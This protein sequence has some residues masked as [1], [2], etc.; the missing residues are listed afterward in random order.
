MKLSFVIIFIF[1][2]VFTSCNNDDIPSTVSD[3]STNNW[4]TNSNQPQLPFFSETEK[5]ITVVSEGPRGGSFIPTIGGL[6]AYRLFRI[7]IVNSNTVA[8]ELEMSLEKTVGLIRPALTDSLR[9]WLIPDAYVPSAKVDQFNF[10]IE[11]LEKLL[12]TCQ[13]KSPQI[14]CQ[15]L[16]Q[17]TKYVYLVALYKQDRDLARALVYFTHQPPVVSFLPTDT[18]AA[19]NNNE[20]SLGL[21]FGIGIDPPTNYAYF[22]CG[23]ITF[24]SF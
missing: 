9:I 21:T 17:L 14:K 18:S 1:S 13:N 19:K 8:A 12:D 7:G 15:L 2:I 6:M 16:P 22:S 23:K 11:N 20:I 24:H 3:T 5:G 4:T 10:G